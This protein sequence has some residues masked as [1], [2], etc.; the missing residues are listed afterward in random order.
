MLSV[1]ISPPVLEDLCWGQT[2]TILLLLVVLDMLAVH[3]RAKGV[4][5]GL[6]TAFKIYPG[7]FIIVFLLRRQWRA[8]MN[9]VATT[10]AVTTGLAWIL[11]PKS[12]SYFFMKEFLGG[13]GLVHLRVGSEAS[14]SSSVIDFFRRAPFSITPNTFETA[15]AF[16]FVLTVGLFGAY[17]L[18][19]QHFE[20]SS[21]LIVLIVS[22]VG[23]PVAW[24]RCHTLLPL[25]C[26]V[27]INWGGIALWA[28]RQSP[29]R[30]SRRCRGFTSESQYRAHG[31]L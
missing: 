20:L 3:G 1:A 14:A 24:D 29:R 6:A 26:L 16:M 10:S 30:S 8:A 28:A 31:G 27:P 22:V 21:M 5:I 25:L 19:R 7:V 2:G 13:G 9:A 23:A 15:V 12:A 4:L 18:W 11:W 17:K